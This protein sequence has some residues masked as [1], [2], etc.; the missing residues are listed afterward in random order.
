LQQ[1]THRK[2]H[3]RLTAILLAAILLPVP[4]LADTLTYTYT[5]ND[6][7]TVYRGAFTTSDAVTGSFNIASPLAANLQFQPIYS[8][9]LSFS[10]SDGL[11]TID[12]TQSFGATPIFDVATDAGGNITQW[13]IDLVS[14]DY[15]GDY[16][17]E[18]STFNEGGGGDTGRTANLADLAVSASAGTWAEAVSVAPAPEPA[19][20]L[21]LATGLI[22]LAGFL[23]RRHG[24]SH[25]MAQN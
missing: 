20:L 9:L 3:M 22:G 14:G 1:L 23:R 16:V 12:S 13:D 2:V 17:S 5:G 21:L 7:T 15:L 19:T 6:F 8:S 11:S 4:A 25:R 18:I 24:A 10:F